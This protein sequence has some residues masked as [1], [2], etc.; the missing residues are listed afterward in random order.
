M[1]RITP[2]LLFLLVTLFVQSCREDISHEQTADHSSNFNALADS[3]I[4]KNEDSVIYYANQS[5]AN[6]LGNES[7]Y[8]S[9]FLLADSYHMKKSFLTAFDYYLKANETI[10][11]GDQ[12]NYDHCAILNQLGKISK[13]HANYDLAIANY[14]KAL[15][16]APESYS[17]IIYR[18][19]GNAYMENNQQ[20]Q[21]TEAYLKAKD[22]ALE[23]N[24]LLQQAKTHHQLGLLFSDLGDYEQARSYFRT[25]INYTGDESAQYQRYRG[26]AYHNLG[27]S[28]LN[29]ENYQKAIPHFEKAKA[30]KKG[31][32][33]FVTYMDLAS[34]YAALGEP[35]AAAENFRMAASLYSKVEPYK[36]NIDLFKKMHLFYRENEDLV[37][38]N[39]AIDRYIEEI[40]QFTH[41]K[42]SL[43]NSYTAA[44]LEAKVREHE[45]NQW[46][47]EL[48]YKY[49]FY[50]IALSALA[51]LLIIAT[52]KVLKRARKLKT[53]K[54]KF[55]EIKSNIQ[56]VLDGE[57]V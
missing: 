23:N 37:A 8:Y 19:L 24:D 53:E 45:K 29:E 31:K 32:E 54:N 56:R 49:R 1:K 9:Y 15:N 47:E 11:S 10:P 14:K 26:K 17:I 44:S 38:G 33:K 41:T 27:S 12:Y 48:I 46:F 2:L 5:L 43:L 39:Q 34:C 36:K 18:N 35:K 42:E 4:G 13:I 51:I 40:D 57:R 25:I 21:A 6:G 28:Y 55:L 20:E 16:Y 22:I 3:F 50:I 30:L 7:D 52:I